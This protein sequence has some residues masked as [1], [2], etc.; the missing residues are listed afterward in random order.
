MCILDRGRAGRR[1][2]HLVPAALA[3]GVLVQGCLSVSAGTGSSAGADAGAAG[4]SGTTQEI[5]LNEKPDGSR[6]I[7]VKG[8]VSQEQN[9]Q[10][11]A[12]AASTAKAT[13]RK[14]DTLFLIS[15]LVI[16]GGILYLLYDTVGKPILRSKGIIR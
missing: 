5:I 3:V 7:R 14:T 9:S 6:E 4:S 13:L 10:A 8:G 1:G 16:A 11:A 2:P 15:M 12:E